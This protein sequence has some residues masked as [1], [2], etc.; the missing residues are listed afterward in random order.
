MADKNISGKKIEE[1]VGRF[2][3]EHSI[4]IKMDIIIEILSRL[5][6]DELDVHQR[7]VAMSFLAPFDKKLLEA[8]K[9]RKGRISP[10]GDPGMLVGPGR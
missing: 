8:Y 6:N 4:G 1:L 7:T 10:G 3:E 2:F 5:E 9:S